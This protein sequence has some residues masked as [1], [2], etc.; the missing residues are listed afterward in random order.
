MDNTIFTTNKTGAE[1][2]PDVVA[3][4]IKRHVV[5]ELPRLAKLEDYYKGEHAILEREKA[6]GLSNIQIVANHAAYISDMAA[7]YLV[8]EPVVYT[9]PDGVNIEP[10]KEALR[11]ADAA[12]QD[13]DLALDVSVFGRGNEMPYMSQD[14]PLKI[15]LARLSP[16]NSFVVYDDTVEQKP[17]F[18]VY[19]LATYDDNGVHTGYKGQYWTATH[20]TDI[21]LDA[22]HK[23]KSAGELVPHYFRDV[24]IVE[25]YNNSNRQGDFEQIISLIDAYNLL[26]SDRINDKEQFVDAL[27]L[28]KGQVLG[29]TSD[30]ELETYQAIKR[31][32][33]M[34]MDSDGDASFL[35]RQFDEAA[36]EILRK[37]LVSDIHKFSRV[38]DMTDMNFA[39]NASGV[40]M[41]YKLLGFD[42]LINIKERYFAEGLRHRLRLFQSIMNIT[43]Q[44]F[45]VDDI[46]IK[47]NYSLPANEL[48]E[49]QTVATLGDNVPTTLKLSYLS[50]V[51]D[52]EEIA[53]QLEEEQTKTAQRQRETVFNTPLTVNETVNE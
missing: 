52:P 43:G 36:L 42:N 34:T 26:Q 30:E 5:N 13:I 4:F 45:D 48:E 38:P 33:V 44:G 2:T 23:I 8:G 20:R 14:T 24:P 32:K 10:L 27:L 46:D 35:T 7:G 51:K 49:A 3:K 29:D 25:Y 40:A 47:F 22:Q 18:G 28:I 11:K 19:Y 12:T 21:V 16:K 53:R 31:N 39:S 6:S 1:I 15:K 37:A 50:S 41:R 17:V 9:A